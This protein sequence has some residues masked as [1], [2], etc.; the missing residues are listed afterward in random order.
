M[1]HVQCAKNIKSHEHDYVEDCVWNWYELILSF[2]TMKISNK[3]SMEFRH[4][5]NSKLSL[6]SHHPTLQSY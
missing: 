6:I 3:M 1:L 4:E 5:V 2:T